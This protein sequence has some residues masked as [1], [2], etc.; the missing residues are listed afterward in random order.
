MTETEIFTNPKKQINENTLFILL[1][2]RAHGEITLPSIESVYDTE[3]ENYVV[4]L[5]EINAIKK[6]FD[7]AVTYKFREDIENLAFVKGED[8]TNAYKLFPTYIKKCDFENNKIKFDFDNFLQNYIKEFLSVHI[9]LGDVSKLKKYLSSYLTTFDKD[10]DYNNFYPYESHKVLL[11]DYYKYNKHKNFSKKEKAFL[12]R[13]FDSKK[14]DRNYIS[15]YKMVEYIAYS[16]ETHKLNVGRYGIELCDDKIPNKIGKFHKVISFIEEKS[17]LDEKLNNSSNDKT[18]ELNGF[19]LSNNSISYLGSGQIELSE[20]NVKLFE[21]ASKNKNKDEFSYIEIQKH[22]KCERTR[23]A[24]TD[25]I[26]KLNNK[27]REDFPIG[28]KFTLFKSLRKQGM[29]GY[30]KVNIIND[31]E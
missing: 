6:V 2:L 17:T 18:Y 21:F 3:K 23:Q 4:A 1:A 11:K 28:K 19:H 25:A 30:Y 10:D 7:L 24:V 20:Q 22:I 26:Y 27:L 29:I 13:F 5:S 16:N 31:F 15:K 14:L 9:K 12:F 8:R